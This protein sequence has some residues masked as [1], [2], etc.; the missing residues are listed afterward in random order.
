MDDPVRRIRMRTSDP[1]EAEEFLRR[2]YTE[3]TAQLFG[4]TERFRFDAALTQAG[5]LGVERLAHSMRV[6]AEAEPPHCVYVVQVLGGT[7]EVSAGRNE[8]RSGPGDL[9][10]CDPYAP[11]LAEWDNVR[12]GVVRIGLREVER[13]AADLAEGDTATA[14][15]S[16]A[17]PVSPERA[18]YWQAVVR[19]ISHDVLGNPQAAGSPLILDEAARLLATAVLA[20]FPHDHAELSRLP[21]PGW[22]APAALRRAMAYIDANAARPLTLREIATAARTSPRAL[23]HAFARHCE[24]TPTGYLR[25]VRLEGAHRDLQAADPTSGV[26]VSAVAARW[27]FAKA[28]RFA[29]QYREQFGMSPSRTLRG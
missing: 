14:R 11:T 26:T 13:V 5:A 22:L 20:T 6:R 2:T 18:R 16:F 8:L 24:T 28:G 15:L 1:Q 19:H 7:L 27:G 4:E 21:S 3:H 29:S 23:Q 25:R 17:R 12:L 10:V 9:H